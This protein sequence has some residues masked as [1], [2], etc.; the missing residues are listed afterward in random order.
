MR[1]GDGGGG[2]R[3]FRQGSDVKRLSASKN[4]ESGQIFKCLGTV[5]SACPAQLLVC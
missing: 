2:K 3:R 5:F 1:G 4:K